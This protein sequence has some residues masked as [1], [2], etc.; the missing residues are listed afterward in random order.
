MTE[1]DV[2]EYSDIGIKDKG[3]RMEGKDGIDR[4]VLEHLLF[5]KAVGEGGIRV[6]KYLEILREVNEGEHL[7]MEDSRDRTAAMIFHLVLSEGFNPWDIDL[8][9]FAALYLERMGE[10][11]DFITAGR[12]MH[13]AYRILKL[14][15]KELLYS[16]LEP[17]EDYEDSM[18]IEEWMEDDDSYNY[19]TR[20]VESPEPPIEERIIRKG[21]R[22]VTLFELVEAFRTAE[23]EAKR[24]KEHNLRMK[25][26]RKRQEALR[27]RNRK[28][29]GERLHEEDYREDIKRVYEVLTALGKR[30]LTFQELTRISPVDNVSTFISLL[31]LSFNEKLV[32]YQENFPEG[33][34]HIEMPIISDILTE[35]SPNMNMEKMMDRKKGDVELPGISA[36]AHN[37]SDSISPQE[38]NFIHR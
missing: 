1:S 19:T 36:H 15:S 26:E 12:L 16:L 31:F 6:E 5:H 13:M 25:E 33:E 17:E 21:K 3:E 23:E 9:R 18:D 38:L 27:R 29:V 10:E 4:M 37:Y 35:K 24:M 32:I 8:K 30:H 22:R 28:R 11:L 20:V 2:E 34:I 14:Q 7:S